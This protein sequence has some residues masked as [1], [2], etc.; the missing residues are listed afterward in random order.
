MILRFR[1]TLFYRYFA[2]NT[3]M[4]SLA[5]SH[6][7]GGTVIFH[8]G[9][10]PEHDAAVQAPR[11]DTRINSR[12]I[13]KPLEHRYRSGYYVLGLGSSQGP[14]RNDRRSPRVSGTSSPSAV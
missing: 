4:P 10:H 6:S 11:I 14:G 12:T 2:S 3:R 9:I 8:S 5:A 7:F 1:G 13:V